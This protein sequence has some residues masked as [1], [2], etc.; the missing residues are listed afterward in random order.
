MRHAHL[1]LAL[2]A[3]ATAR[4]SAALYL[5]TDK[6]IGVSLSAEAFAGAKIEG[7]GHAQLMWK[8]REIFKTTAKGSLNAGVGANFKCEAMVPRVGAS[9]FALEMGATLGVGAGAG[10]TVEFSMTNLRLAGE[11]FLYE[12]I[13][14]AFVKEEFRYERMM[15]DVENRIL[16]GQVKATVQQKL[17]TLESQRLDYF[18]ADEIR[19]R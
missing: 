16:L 18:K 7:E 5:S 13:R 8:G 12:E 10:T 6:G 19:R 4:T 3:G 11:Q 9:T 15:G 14:Q 1:L 2:F 17:N